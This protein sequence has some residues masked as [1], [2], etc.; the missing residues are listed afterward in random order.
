MRKVT[1]NDINNFIGLNRPVSERQI[2]LAKKLTRRASIAKVRMNV[3]P[4]MGII[5]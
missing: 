5:K 3:L 4:K 1:P 2:K